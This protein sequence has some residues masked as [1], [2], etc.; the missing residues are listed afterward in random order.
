[1]QQ[2]AGPR[3]A[4]QALSMYANEVAAVEPHPHPAQPSP[5]GTTVH[6]RNRTPGYSRPRRSSRG[7]LKSAG[8]LKPAWS[9]SFC[10]S[11]SASNAIASEKINPPTTA[12]NVI[13][14]CIRFSPSIFTETQIRNR[15]PKP[16][17]LTANLSCIASRCH[18]GI[19][20]ENLRHFFVALSTNFNRIPDAQHGEQLLHIAI[21][22]PD[23]SMRSGVADG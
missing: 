11:S 18:G 7:Q 1:M 16:V 6:D 19:A 14:I 9:F 17:L 3:Q 23:A 20:A 15:S 13:A 2:A 21:A 22:Q 8:T 5:A 12:K 4:T 10:I